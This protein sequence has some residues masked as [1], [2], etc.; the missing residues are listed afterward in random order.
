MRRQ[1]MGGI[2]TGGCLVYLNDGIIKVPRGSTIMNGTVTYPSGYHIA[3]D[4]E[5]ID[6]TEYLTA[7][8]EKD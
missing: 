2:W 3:N 8:L 5:T 7:Y 1:S 4:T 6:E